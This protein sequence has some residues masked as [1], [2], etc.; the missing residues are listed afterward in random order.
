[1]RDAIMMANIYMN[2]PNIQSFSSILAGF[3]EIDRQTA[4]DQVA[5]VKFRYV[6]HE[7]CYEDGDG[8]DDDERWAETDPEPGL[9]NVTIYISDFF[10]RRIES[11]NLVENN[12]NEFFIILK[13][14]VD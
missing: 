13:V 6:R 2:S 3:F 4:A 8:D 14:K 11:T 9:E 5:R 10:P 12:S 1:M 7:D